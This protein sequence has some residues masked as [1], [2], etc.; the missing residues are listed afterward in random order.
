MRYQAEIIN[1]QN[2][3]DRNDR[4]I[5]DLEV[6]EQQAIFA[7]TTTL[8]QENELDAHLEYDIYGCPK[9]Y[10]DCEKNHQVLFTK[11]FNKSQMMNQRPKTS[12]MY[13]K[14]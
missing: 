5:Q 12:R 14:K 2:K 4:I 7:L 3:V 11:N 1:K 9:D 10:R 6:Q 8:G 13:S